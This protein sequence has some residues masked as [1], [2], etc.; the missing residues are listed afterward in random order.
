MWASPEKEKEAE[1]ERNQ[2]RGRSIYQTVPFHMIIC[3][4]S[5]SEIIWFGC[6]KGIF[7][8]LNTDGG[9]SAAKGVGAESKV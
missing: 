3:L 6:V 2:E 9:T 5:L 1:M 4:H 8:F 7:A